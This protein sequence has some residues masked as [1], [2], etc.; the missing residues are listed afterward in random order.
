MK[1]IGVA[2]AFSLMPLLLGAAESPETAEAI[3]AKAEAT[4]AKEGKTVFVHFGAS[5][6]GWCRRLDALLE[7]PDFKPVFDRH[8]VSVKLVTSETAERKALENPGSEKALA[9]L[10]GMN[11]GLPYFAF[12][13]AKGE[14]I[15]NSKL[16]GANIG[17]PGSEEEI[18]FFASLVKKAA[19]GI[20]DADFK[21]MVGVL[22][23]AKPKPAPV[24]A[25]PSPTKPVAAASPIVG[26]DR[27]DSSPKSR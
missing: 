21:A 14:S 5:W 9:R 1:S 2:L 19:P 22:N 8:F 27:T 25:S 17:Y 26:A 12:L 4:A 3:L 16:H 10:D 24:A 13:N 20:S 6:C 15:A 11:S 23:D 18:A 7:R